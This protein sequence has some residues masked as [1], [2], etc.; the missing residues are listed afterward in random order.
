MLRFLTRSLLVTVVVA[1]AYAQAQAPRGRA[2]TIEDYYRIKTVGAPQLSP[3]AKWVAFT[4]STR[5]EETNG[6]TS[7]VWLVPTDASAAARRL[8]RDGVSASNPSWSND[9]SLMYSAGG[10]TWRVADLRAGTSE[11]STSAPSAAGGRGGRGGRGGGAGAARI[12]SPDGK[13][14][15]IVQ[16][17]RLAP[18]AKAELTEFEKRHEDRFKG[19][20]FDWMDFHRDGAAFNPEYQGPGNQSAPGDFPERSRGHAAPPAHVPRPS[21]H[22][23]AMVVRWERTDFQCRLRLSQR[24]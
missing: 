20:I 22:G 15:A 13:L 9:G 19:A 16:D 23:G 8:S 24:A 14:T 10:S 12:A 6:N 1:T 2:L 4:V 18:R 21:S 7:E 5:V 17:V 3:D 11:P